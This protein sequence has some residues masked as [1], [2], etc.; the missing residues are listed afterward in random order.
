MPK[1][2]TTNFDIK[3]DV[4]KDMFEYAEDLKDKLSDDELE[5]IRRFKTLEIYQ[6]DIFMLYAQGYSLREIGA[7]L[8][9]SYNWVR[10]RLKEINYI[11]NN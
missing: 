1:I 7:K 11:I 10:D 4:V 2:I 8:N 3:H 6:Q 9:V 5:K